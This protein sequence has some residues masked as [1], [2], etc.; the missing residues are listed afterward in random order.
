MTTE[1]GVLLAAVGA[2]RFTEVHLGTVLSATVLPDCGANVPID[3]RHWIS[4]GVEA[5]QLTHHGSTI[6]ATYHTA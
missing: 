1:S 6:I 4:D 3:E 5:P 2:A